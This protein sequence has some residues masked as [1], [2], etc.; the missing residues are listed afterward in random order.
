MSA[1]KSLKE[2]AC[3]VY[4]G[5]RIQW[6]QEFDMLRN[7]VANTIRLEGRWKSPG[8]K[9][10]SFVGRN[11]DFSMTWYPGKLNSP[12]FFGRDGDF[13]KKL[14][15]SVLNSDSTTQART[16]KDELFRA[17]AGD[18]A[19]AVSGVE[20]HNESFEAVNE[21]IVDSKRPSPNCVCACKVHITDFKNVK[22]DVAVLHKQIE[23]INR[24]I[25][26]TNS[27]NLNPAGAEIRGM[28]YD[29]RLETLLNEFSLVLNEK[30]RQLEERDNIIAELQ[31][32]LSKIGDQC[33]NLPIEFIQL[34]L[35]MMNVPN[36]SRV[37]T[38]EI[39]R[40]LSVIAVKT[41]LLIL[42]RL[43]LI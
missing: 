26:S 19:E 25:E 42:R 7:F 1:I 11:C 23:S 10:K 13:I 3:L 2:Q 14:L 29:L 21:I 18:V 43:I 12:L 41:L 24:V 16:D 6:N 35:Y 31:D 37:M 40:R 28:S 8:G 36:K 4:D 17:A 32:K 38:I 27:I 33:Q 5:T 34:N 15:M 20:P 22:S 39:T 30:N 9:A